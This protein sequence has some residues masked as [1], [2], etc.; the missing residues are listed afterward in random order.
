MTQ[1]L[2]VFS[3]YLNKVEGLVDGGLGVEGEAS[4]NLGRDLAGDDLENLLAKLNEE[5]VEGMVNL[6]LDVT[7]LLLTVL[8]G[9]I[10]EL[11]VLGLLGGSEN[12]GRVGGGILRLVLANGCGKKKKS[13]PIH[14]MKPMG[15]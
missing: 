1:R 14:I 9:N 10:H 15:L 6:G 8:N 5:T 13:A 7:T 4:V 3:A 12:Q 2:T 11:G